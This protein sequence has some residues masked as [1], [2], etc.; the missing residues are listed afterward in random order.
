MIVDFLLGLLFGLLDVLA[1]LLPGWT[2]PTLWSDSGGCGAGS[3]PALCQIG[4]WLSNLGGWIDVTVLVTCLVVL[5]AAWAVAGVVR[6][7]VWIY[8]KIPAKGSA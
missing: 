3:I 4:A 5:A 2:D 1:G 6:G 7:V 8:D